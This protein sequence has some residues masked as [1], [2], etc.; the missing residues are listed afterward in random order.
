VN[1]LDVIETLVDERGLDKEKVV[2]IIC[3][4]IKAAYQKKFPDL[5][6]A[7]EFNKKLGK[8]EVFL[9]KEVV[10]TVSEDDYEVTQRK[11]APHAGEASIGDI[12]RIP[13]D[14]HIGRIEIAATRQIIGG[15]IRELEQLAVYDEFEDKKGTIVSGT[16]HKRERDGVVVNIGDVSAFLPAAGSIPGE[17]LRVGHPVRALLKEVLQIARGG[18]QLIL[19]RGSADFAKRLIEL[20]IPEVFE[21]I[22]EIRKIE[23]IAGYKTKV[24]VYSNSKEIDPV[25]T[26]VGV[27]GGRIRPI[28]KE[29]GKE[30]VDLI[31]WSKEI[32]DL[33]AESLKPAEV[34]KVGM[35]SDETAMVWLAQ[36]QRSLAIGKMGQNIT[37]ASRLTG[38]EI[39]LQELT[40]PELTADLSG[41][42]SED[43]ASSDDDA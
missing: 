36:D 1:L 41:S 12:V 6:F 33:V 18:Y 19:D 8:A 10:A 22:V 42:F 29:L 21:G 34:D 4:G 28:L 40:T 32:E 24:V 16:I 31:E 20:E 11:A 13:F 14:R 35:V 30:K 39:Q 43:D 2:A 9:E 38:V 27:G 5:D 37:L 25:G 17:A 15:K 26:C 7:V 23:R 3:D